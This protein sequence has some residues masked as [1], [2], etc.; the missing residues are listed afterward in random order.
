MQMSVA[1]IAQQQG[2]RLS[3]SP[4]RASLLNNFLFAEVTQIRR[5]KNRAIAEVCH[6][7][8]RTALELAHPWSCEVP[9]ARFIAPKDLNVNT[10]QTAPSP[11]QDAPACE[12][13]VPYLLVAGIYRTRT[14]HQVLPDF[15]LY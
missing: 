9:Q 15:M 4:R 12:T 13:Y 1:R 6:P 14:K 8:R 5:Q 7:E 2:W 11:A 3:N 10:A